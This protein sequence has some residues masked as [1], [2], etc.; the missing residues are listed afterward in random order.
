MH[1]IEFVKEIMKPEFLN[2][3]KKF[4]RDS[5]TI[6][7][8]KDP[9][10]GRWCRV[11]IQ[12]VKRLHQ[13]RK[14]KTRADD[15]KGG[16]FFCPK[17]IEKATPKFPSWLI[18][19]GRIKINEFVLF[20][21]LF[22]FGEYHAV[23]VLCKRHSLRLHEITPR[24]WED[25][26]IGCIE[27]FR[28]INKKNLD[29]RFPSINLN[30]SPSAGASIT[31]P[32]VQVLVDKLPTVMTDEYFRRSWMYFDKNKTNYWQDL[33]IKERNGERF[34]GESE[35]M[36]WLTSFAPTCNDEIIGIMKGNVS[37]FFELSDEQIHDLGK[38]ICRIFRGLYRI[39]RITSANMSI[40]SAPF[41]E[42]LGHFFSLNVKIIS[43]PSSHIYTS[44]R[45]FFE[46]LH[47]EPVVST[48][49]EELAKELRKVF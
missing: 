36:A 4:E 43:R 13:G 29:A 46:I 39:K 15:F 48:I 24:M 28:A 7:R 22:P 6:E 26:L 21:N 8:R 49:P 3:K 14:S 10:T 11:N 38:G 34:V 17:N 31:H 40:F 9:L 30:Y 41:D 12:R 44:D 5:Q 1:K 35:T 2:P 16:C 33:I 23:G 19:E 32:H 45:G 27:F 25:C 47:G 18:P 37:S 42:H 20:P